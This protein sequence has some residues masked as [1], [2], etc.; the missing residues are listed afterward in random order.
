MAIALDQQGANNDTTKIV[1]PEN[2]AKVFHPR[3]KGHE[4]LKILANA[5][6][7][8]MRPVESGQPVCT[9]PVPDV[10]PYLNLTIGDD[11]GPNPP[12]APQCRGPADKATSRDSDGG[13]NIPPPTG[14]GESGGP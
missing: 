13:G 6:L 12:P 9:G 10:S 2:F 8:F 11:G 14:D 4:A 3:T 7:R 1:L 5:G